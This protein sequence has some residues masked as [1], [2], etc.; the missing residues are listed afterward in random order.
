MT[1]EERLALAQRA[2]ARSRADA[3]E[4]TVNATHQGL[5]RFTRETLHQNVDEAD[6]TVT[7]R[8]IVGGR[9]GIASTNALDDAALGTVNDRAHELATLAPPDT[10][11]PL[12]ATPA[13]AVTPPGAYVARTAGADPA[14]RSA[15]AGAIFAHA[16]DAGLWSSGYVTTTDSGVTIATTAGAR[17]TFDGTSAGINVKMTGADA[18]GWAE[19]NAVDV[20]ALD[21]DAVGARAASKAVAA[22]AP[23][24][25]EPGEWTVILEPAALGELLAFFR[26]YFSAELYAEGASYISERL[27]ERIAGENVTI[28]D[29]YA[30]PLNPGMPFDFAGVPTQRL[31]LVENGIARS[32]VTDDVW[33]RRLG[34]PDTGHAI[35]RS[36]GW[37]MGP[38]STYTVVDPGPRPV[39]ELIAET[40][41]GLLITRFWYVRYVDQRRSIVT[42]MTRDGTFAIERGKV[43][44]GVRNMRFNVAL[45]DLLEDCEF[46]NDPTRTAG[47]GHSVVTPSVKFSRFRFASV[48]PY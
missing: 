17:F 40:P 46:A 33:A 6:V 47:Y 24:A 43:R 39:E 1:A 3:A 2:L 9:V 18:T 48:S 20:G 45:G 21:G 25:V 19:S 10:L 14:L 41:R 38:Q 7:V 22:A 42:G 4:V 28:R 11:P 32:I 16:K 23:V 29:D 15:I 34:R 26:P 8:A 13:D 31:A 36:G 12:V 44:G 37:P 35:P 27:G 5:S 30:N